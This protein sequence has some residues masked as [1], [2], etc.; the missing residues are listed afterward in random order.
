MNDYSIWSAGNA[1]GCRRYDGAMRGREC[2]HCKQSVEPGGNTR[3]LDHRIKVVH[4][5]HLRHLD[6][7]ETPVTGWLEEAYEVSDGLSAK[8]RGAKKPKKTPGKKRRAHA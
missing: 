5:V 2:C 4:I 8:G 7:V 1:L 6:E 3:L